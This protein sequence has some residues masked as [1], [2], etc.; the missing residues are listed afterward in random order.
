MKFQVQDVVFALVFS[1]IDAK[2]FQV[3]L[4]FIVYLQFKDTKRIILDFLLN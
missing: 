2:K 3:V 1:F 4:L